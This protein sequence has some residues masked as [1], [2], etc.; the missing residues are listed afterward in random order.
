MRRHDR[1]TASI[2]PMDCMTMAG[3]GAQDPVSTMVMRRMPH[4][5]VMGNAEINDSP[6]SRLEKPMRL[7]SSSSFLAMLGVRSWDEL[8]AVCRELPPSRFCELLMRLATSLPFNEL[9]GTDARSMFIQKHGHDNNAGPRIPREYPDECMRQA[10]HD[11]IGDRGYQVAHLAGTFGYSMSTTT[12]L[13]WKLLLAE[14]I[15]DRETLLRAAYAYMYG[16]TSLDSG[17]A[18]SVYRPKPNAYITPRSDA[19]EAGLM[20]TDVPCVIIDMPDGAVPCI[21]DIRASL[22]VMGGV[23]PQGLQLGVTALLNLFQQVAE[24]NAYV[25]DAAYRP[26]GLC[27]NDVSDRMLGRY[28][29]RHCDH[30]ARARYVASWWAIVQTARIQYG[31]AIP[32]AQAAGLLCLQRLNAATFDRA[33]TLAKEITAWVYDGTDIALDR[34]TMNLDDT[35]PFVVQGRNDG[36][37]AMMYIDGVA[38]DE[39]WIRRAQDAVAWNTRRERERNAA[40]ERGDR[41]EPLPIVWLVNAAQ[42]AGMVFGDAAPTEVLL[43]GSGHDA[44]HVVFDHDR[45]LLPGGISIPFDPVATVSRIMDQN[46][47]TDLSAS[48]EDIVE[49]VIHDALSD[50]KMEE[51]R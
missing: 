45:F 1:Q 15:H 39:Y 20:L 48:M 50:E 10:L 30:E 7:C 33:L 18:W 16:K 37:V 23:D 49:H 27:I 47:S 34:V 51:I 42:L 44:W 19:G 40:Q 22:D 13:A 2:A 36:A 8:A 21:N 32:P 17:F 12:T 38:L 46:A 11:A 5:G 4:A 25:D 35:L 26:W 41:Y 14:G 3:L 28:D 29:P 9:V 31:M 24:Y 6:V 43:L